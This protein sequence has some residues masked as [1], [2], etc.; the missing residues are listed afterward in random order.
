[1]A[2]LW[3]GHRTFP[4]L[5]SALSGHPVQARALL[6]LGEGMCMEMA[7]ASAPSCGK[8]GESW[9]NLPTRNPAATYDKCLKCSLHTIVPSNI[10]SLKD[11]WLNNK[12]HY[13]R[14]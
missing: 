8:P 11:N 3:E 6:T 7:P 5:S 9:L 13:F 14:K 10:L 4:L 1:M 2:V 12:I